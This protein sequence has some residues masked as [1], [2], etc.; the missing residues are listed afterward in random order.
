M[1]GFVDVERKA[2]GQEQEEINQAALNGV[3]ARHSSRGLGGR[4]SQQLYG[5]EFRQFHGTSEGSRYVDGLFEFIEELTISI[6]II[7]NEEV[8]S[9][10]N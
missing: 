9:K 10:R 7:A 5:E 8:E 3:G 4:E 6:F 2:S 1:A